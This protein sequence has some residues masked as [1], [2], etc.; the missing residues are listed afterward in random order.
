M[1]KL[2]FNKLVENK[3]ESNY[4]VFSYTNKLILIKQKLY[5]IYDV[6]FMY[7]QKTY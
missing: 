4:Y 6:K 2:I 1:K 3:L 5:S 7:K